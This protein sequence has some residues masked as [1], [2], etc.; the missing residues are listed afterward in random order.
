MFKLHYQ[1][2]IELIRIFGCEGTKIFADLFIGHTII[3]SRE[4][5]ETD[6]CKPT[7]ALYKN[8]KMQES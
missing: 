8:G 5:E 3:I 2:A 1:N 4:I 6:L 7:N